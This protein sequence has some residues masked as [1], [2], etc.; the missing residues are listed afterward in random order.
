MQSVGQ[1]VNRIEEGLISFFFAAMVLITFLQVVLRYCFNEGFVW[2]LELTTYC[3]AWMV[4]IGISWGV[5]VNTH[6]GVDA[7]VKLFPGR[8][9]RALILFG[10][11]CCIAYAA[12]LLIGAWEYISKI[13]RIGIATEDLYVPRFLGELIHGSQGYE[14]IPIPRWIPYSA[15]PIGLTL[16]LFRFVQAFWLLLTGR[17]ATLIAGHEAEEMAEEAKR[18]GLA[19]AG[20]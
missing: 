2:A 8:V 17:R 9:Q 3:F 19:D 14:E 16:L 12:I 1:V 15:L 6:L 13:Y 4:L 18:G 10:C 20:R 11:L 7:F 5:K